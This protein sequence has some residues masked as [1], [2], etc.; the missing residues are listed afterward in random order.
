MPI[1]ARVMHYFQ[2]AGVP[3]QQVLHD[4]AE[5]LCQALEKAGLPA[6]STAIAELLISA[7]G[8][9]MSVVP[10][11]HTTDL[12]RLQAQTGH[13]WQRLTCHQ[14][15]KVFPDCEPGSFPP[16]GGAY[17]LPLICDPSI[18]TWTSVVLQSGCHTTLVLLSQNAAAR[19]FASARQLSVSRPLVSESVSEPAAPEG[20]EE[21]LCDRL[22]R[23]YQL[24]PMPEVASRI[25]TMSQ[26]PELDINRLCRELERDPS[27]T[28]QIL[29]EAASARYAYRGSLDSLEQAVVRVLGLQRVSQMAFALAAGQGFD[30]PREGRLGLDA[31]WQHGLL[32]ADL[33]Q[34]LAEELPNIGVSPQRAYLAGLLH[35]FGWLVLGQLFRPE[36]CLLARKADLNPEVSIRDLEAGSLGFSGKGSP[37]HQGHARLGAALLD[38]WKLPADLVVTAREHHNPGYEGPHQATVRLVREA[39]RL[40]GLVGIGDEPGEEMP[41][42]ACFPGYESQAVARAVARCEGLKALSQQALA[43]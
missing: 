11:G 5:T 39:N 9:L 3:W 31:F 28:A 27:L 12:E 15:R 7:R 42:A 43:G 40:L 6:S 18:L 38:Q 10:F 1:A 35:N 26:D 30:L 16:I 4:R 2:S 25:L 36:Y 17:R 22:T 13:S 21:R 29:R 8:V 41:E 24:P 34:K 37:A 23:L 14:A 33:S 32:C 20:G 19:V